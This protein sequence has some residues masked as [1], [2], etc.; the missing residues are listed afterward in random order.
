MIAT[1]LSMF[2][3]FTDRARRVL[4][5]AQEEA[6]LLNN[7]FIGTEHLLLG[8]IHEETGVAARALS[9]LGVTLD[10]ARERVGEAGAPTAPP[11]TS[12]P[13]TPRAKKVLEL[14]LREAL[15]LG[16]NYISTEH[17]LLGIVREG[18]GLAARVLREAGIDPSRV[19]QEVIRAL[20]GY[21]SI[22]EDVPAPRQ[23]RPDD[24]P[25]RCPR[26]RAELSDNVRYRALDVS[27]GAPGDPE[28]DLL[29]VYCERCSTVLG[30]LPRRS[31][32]SRPGE[33][34]A[35]SPNLAGELVVLAPLAPAHVAEL[36]RILATPE[37]RRRWGDEAASADWPFDDRSTT[38]FAVVVDGR[39]RGMVQYDEE[40]D[41]AYRHASID[42]FLDPEVHGRRYGRDAVT[43]LAHHLIGERGHRRLVID[44]AADNEPAIRCY[45]AVGF[46]PVG[47]M[48]RYER[49][50]DGTGW[51]DGLLMDLLA[52]DLPVGEHRSVDDSEE[53]G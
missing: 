42:V 34:T 36:R 4:V 51:H 8:L 47:V 49:D 40:E 24:E 46:R 14:A 52:E 7:G 28:L 2:E 33:V 19:R 43:T 10:M 20:S 50:A 18:G 3:R 32:D 48:R 37:V 13:F 27:S 9:A 22:A 45:T 39:V 1:L 25:P 6:R 16:H 30:S 44:P 35:S 29:F 11:T 12:P 31:A 5:L 38:R 23:E 26:C 15:Q 41:P 17:L 21:E 53:S